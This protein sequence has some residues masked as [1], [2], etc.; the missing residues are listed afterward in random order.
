[1]LQIF[2]EKRT[3]KE[4][5]PVAELSVIGNDLQVG[6]D[7]GALLTMLKGLA[8]RP[9]CCVTVDKGAVSKTP[10]TNKFKEMLRYIKRPYF[11]SD[12]VERPWRYFEVIRL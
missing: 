9:L 5:R 3:H 1:M 10:A 8:T 4:T 11:F 12:K 2:L 6:T 7:D